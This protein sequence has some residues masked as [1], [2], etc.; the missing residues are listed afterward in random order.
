M[1]VFY[2]KL[3]SKSFYLIICS[4]ILTISINSYGNL[5]DFSKIKNT[6]EKK[7]KFFNYLRPIANSTNDNILK[8]RK[9]LIKTFKNKKIDK[10][11]AAW[12]AKI[13]NN[14][15]IKNWDINSKTKQK[16]LL[17][18]VDIIPTSLI[19]AQAANESAWGTSRFARKGNNIFGQWCFTKGCGII[20]KKRPK[21]KTYAVKKFASVK[22]SVKS[23]IHNLNTNHHY[24]YFRE[25]RANLRSKNKELNGIYLTQG[26]MNYSTRKGSYI[27]D[28]KNMIANNKL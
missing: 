18:K 9:K 13:A 24:K 16:E 6:K 15:G 8:T 5:P 4:F 20:P 25:L 1:G 10:K 14:Y 22:D 27:A 11:Q 23:Y 26:L 19:L 28:L 21:G 2:M 12:V 17:S 3:L 7:A